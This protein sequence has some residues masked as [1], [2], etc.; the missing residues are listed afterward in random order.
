MI[1]QYIIGTL[2]LQCFQIKIPISYIYIFNRVWIVLLNKDNSQ[3][4]QIKQNACE[5]TI[6]TDQCIS[7]KVMAEEHTLSVTSLQISHIS[8]FFNYI[9]YFLTFC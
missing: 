3:A 6:V 4:I 1:N 8:L 7:C 2:C 5:G 9:L